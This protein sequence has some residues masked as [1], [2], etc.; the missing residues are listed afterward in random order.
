MGINRDSKIYVAGHTGMVGSAIVRRLKMEGYNNLILKKRVD[1]DLTNQLAVRTFYKQNK[2]E[3][4]FLGAA[5]VGGIHA[6]NIYRA[7]FIYENL[8]IQ[9]NLIHFANLYGVKK[10]LFLGSSCIYPR[11]SKQPIK[12]EYLLAGPLEL[13][14]EPYAVAKISGIKMCESYARQYG[15]NF[16]SV[17]P[18]NLY[19][20]NDNYDLKNSHVIPALIKKFI[21]AKRS[22]QNYVTVWGTGNARREF[23]HSDDLADGLLFIMEHL[24]AEDLIKEKISHINI[25]TGFDITIKELAELIKDI[26]G[27]DGN[28]LYDHSKPD[29]TPKKCLDCTRI[30][31]LGWKSTIK[32]EDGLRQIASEYN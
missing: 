2:P 3:Y 7:Q 22:N 8:Q 16:L 31:Y 6:N 12:E 17:M 23:L 1:L 30:N 9:N 14:N 26:C 20:A 27:F 29:G 21:E 24:N 25:G 5:K 11:E 13:T 28:I 19:G 18:T 4:V 32:L 15:S 10:L